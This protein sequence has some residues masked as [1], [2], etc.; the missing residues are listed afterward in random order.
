MFQLFFK[1]KLQTAVFI[2][3]IAAIICIILAANNVALAAPALNST[4]SS[5]SSTSTA[6]QSAKATSCKSDFFGLIP[7][8]G[9]FPDSAFDSASCN[10]NLS[11][12]NSSD[13]SINTTNVN[14]IWLIA[15]AL[16]EDLLI[17]AGM[18]TVGFI[19]YG[20]I[21]Y[22]TSQGEPENTKAAF[23]TIINALIGGAIAAIAAVTISFLGNKL[24]GG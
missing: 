13:G 10:V 2:R 14:S 24:G 21:R 4:N 6:T 11:L 23:S 5:S 1:L 15:L 18:V 3:W 20:G 7:W 16:F 12:V 9:Y 17:I 19:I 8:Y 22:I